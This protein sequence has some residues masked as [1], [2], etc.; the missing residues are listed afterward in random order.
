MKTDMSRYLVV[1]LTNTS[2]N[3]STGGRAPN[4]TN[5]H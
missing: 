5:G 3:S 4:L 2:N 1:I